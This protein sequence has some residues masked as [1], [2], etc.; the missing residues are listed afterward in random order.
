M[1][2]LGDALC[3]RMKRI[4]GLDAED[5]HILEVYSQKIPTTFLGKWKK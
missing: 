5:D 4:D 3:L 2:I 1:F